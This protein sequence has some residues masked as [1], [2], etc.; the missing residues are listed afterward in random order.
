MKQEELDIKLKTLPENPGIYQYF[1]KTG[2]IIYIGKAKNLKKRV[3]SY[4]TK[5]HENGKTTILVRK[6]AD[7]KYI[8][9]NS[10]LDALLLENSLIKKYQPKYNIQLKDDKTYPWICIKKEPFPRVFSTRRIVKDGSKYF[11]PYPSVKSMNTLLHLFKELYSL[12][13]C[14]LD[15]KAEKINTNKYK[16]CLEYHL[17]NCKG[18]CVKLQDEA[19]YQ[20]YIDQI[21]SILK[22][23][24]RL[25]SD[26]IRKKMLISAKN[27]DFETAQLLKEKL[28]TVENFQSKSTIVSPTINEVDVIT[29]VE[30]EKNAFVNYLVIK[31]GAIIH[32]ITSEVQKK[33]NESKED[34]LTYSLLEFRE[35]FNSTSKEVLVE[36]K[37]ELELP[38]FTSFVPRKGD[39]KQL[40]E[41]SKR[42]AAYYRLEKYKNEK[43]K[44]PEAHSD[45]ILNQLKNDLRLKES[46]VHIECFDNSN[47]QGTNP[48][49]ACVVFRN[50]KPSK[51]DYRHFNI[52][53]VVGPDDFASMEEVV[54]RRY[55]RML[56][57]NQELP[58]LIVIDGGKGQLSSAVNAL[59]KIGLRGKVAI[60]GI[61]KRLEEIFF[62]GDSVPIYLDKRSESLK[63][64]QQMRNEAH[65]FGI[66]HH[67]D[68]RSKSALTSELT[69]IPG[70]GPKTFE[71]LMKHF[72][73]L[74]KI[75]NADLESLSAVIGKAK[76]KVVIAYFLAQGKS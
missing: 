32:G 59:E 41:L 40:L 19:E 64:I 76:G 58:Q 28:Q 36:E 16:V 8:V 10:E 61:A 2:T 44:N 15:L 49:A 25:V 54:T 66:T 75:K 63:V 62:P 11:G 26:Y 73:T 68:K 1:D 53:T 6:I 57:E 22:G 74:S 21:E 43:I 7:I 3:S 34:I 27:Y 55:S 39:K 46:P 30:D 48:V 14:N 20:E 60:I 13:T 45:R 71:V 65:R 29:L 38:E 4:F 23:N 17:G 67:R 47:I 37:F 5:N 31:N 56:A 72:K 35:R 50:A 69:Q 9:V 42:N 12:R 33:L 18:P 24:I 51:K 70:I 52:K